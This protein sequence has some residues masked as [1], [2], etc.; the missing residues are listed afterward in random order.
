[1]AYIQQTTPNPL[2]I[3]QDASNRTRISQSTTL[4]DGKVLNGDSTLTWHTKGSGTNTYAD[5]K[6]T[7]SVTAGQYLVRQTKKFLNYSAGKSQQIEVTFDNFHAQAD[8]VKR[9]G[10]FSSISTGTYATSYDGF[11]LEN[12][13]TTISLKSSRLGTSTLSVDITAWS[14]YNKLLEYQSVA[15]WENFTVVEFDFLWLGGAVLRMFVKTSK[16]FV[17]AHVFNYSGTT[18]NTF[19]ASPN[20]PIRYEIRSTTGTGEFHYICSQVSTEG[21]IN[22]SGYNNGWHSLLTAGV[23]SQS[24]ATIGTSYAVC[25]VKKKT[26]HR[27]CAARILSCD[28]MVSSNNDILHWEIVLNPTLSAGLTYTSLSGSCCEFGVAG[29]VAAISITSSSGRILH[30]GF[31]SHG[32]ALPTGTLEEDFLS[33]LGCTIDNVMDEV[34]LVVTPITAAITL[35]GGLNWKEY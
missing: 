19:I 6:V 30:D 5:N 15:N 29:A 34:V 10:Y 17:L 25:G 9:V 12:D 2:E 26:T 18:T 32:Q 28:L 4:H 20:Q 11:W 1:M 21:S 33:F 3:S 16:G 27:D 8:V 31:I 24:V 35:N 23:P 14:G 22:E 13:G 7:L